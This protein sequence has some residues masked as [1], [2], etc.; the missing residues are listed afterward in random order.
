[1]SHKI[2]SDEAPHNHESSPH[3]SRPPR[4]PKGQQ[5]GLRGCPITS[6]RTDSKLSTRISSKYSSL[7]HTFTGQIDYSKVHQ[8]SALTLMAV[9]RHRI[10]VI[11]PVLIQ[12]AGA[13]SPEGAI[14]NCTASPVFKKSSSRLLIVT[15]L[16]PVQSASS[17]LVASPAL[18]AEHGE[19]AV[20]SVPSS[21]FASALIHVS[22]QDSSNKHFINMLYKLSL[23]SYHRKKEICQ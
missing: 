13:S 9:Q 5:A 6:S 16:S 22:S 21:A 3:H 17:G 4:K 14:P 11:R 15:T 12:R 19:G 8:I 1:M 2:W 10:T 23:L 7:R 18:P 20:Y